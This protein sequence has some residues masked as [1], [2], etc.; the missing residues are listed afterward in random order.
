MRGLAIVLVVA[1]HVTDGAGWG[2][3]TGVRRMA[4]ALLGNATVPFVFVSGY[5][6]HHLSARF[7]YLAYLRKR[8]EGV[9]IPYLVVTTPT[10]VH[11]YLNHSDVFADRT[12]PAWLE[13]LGAYS[14]AAHM[15]VPFWYIP[16]IALFYL[17][18][19]ALAALGRSR[20]LPFATLVT[21]LCAVALHRSREHRC[22]WQSALYFLPVYLLGIWVSRD[23][24]TW[25]AALARHRFWLLVL[26]CA[27][28]TLQLPIAH[29]LGPVYSSA[30]FSTEAGSI[31]LDLPAKALLTL[32]LL[33][34]LCNESPLSHRLLPPVASA[35]FGIFFV[36]EY[37]IQRSLG[38]ERWFTAHHP[39]LSA[40]AMPF[41]TVG[42]VALSFLLVRVVQQALGRY[43]RFIIGC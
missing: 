39:L 8:F 16:T 21:L 32:A 1:C 19:P 12:R 18:S 23:R 30:P 25:L 14:T 27:L 41:A 6:F 5:L 24:T 36:H 20:A 28:F 7:R 42:I 13:A 11:Q 29:A 35:S 3:A 22:V 37:V 26:G 34:W 10:L 17:A 4:W 43:S 33:S 31:D 40:L 15:P 38:V 2:H 9:V